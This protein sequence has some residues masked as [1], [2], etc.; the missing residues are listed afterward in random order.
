[1]GMKRLVNSCRREIRDFVHSLHGLL[2]PYQVRSITSCLRL[3]LED[4]PVLLTCKDRVP[5]GAGL[6]PDF[7]G[8][9]V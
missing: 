2:S 9:L 8:G 6:R 1:M 4:T 7:P 5:V 3:R